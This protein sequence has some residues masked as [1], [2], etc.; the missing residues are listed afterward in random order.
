M[1]LGVNRVG[2]AS[3]VQV[4]Q[5]DV[6]LGA[7]E[8][9]IGRLI[10]LIEMV[11]LV[12]VPF[13]SQNFIGQGNA[14]MPMKNVQFTRKIHCFVDNKSLVDT[15]YSSH[16]VEEKRLRVDMAVFQDMMGRGEVSSVS[17]VDTEGQLANCLTKR[18]A[19]A[20][21]LMEVISPVS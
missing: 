2:V 3:V 11:K 21:R 1:I 4:A 6:V 5:T 16:K 13:V 20:V 7:T 18:G 14:Q 12:N 17:W 10:L 8:G 19:S 15:L 9:I